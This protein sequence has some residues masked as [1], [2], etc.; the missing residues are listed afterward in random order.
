MARV[1]T[2]ADV[3]LLPKLATTTRMKKNFGTTSRC[4][5]CPSTLALA[6][7]AMVL[8]RARARWRSRRWGTP[9]AHPLDLADVSFREFV[10]WLEDT[11]IRATPLDSRGPLR[12]V[13]AA[14]WPSAFGALA[15]ETGCELD[16][17]S[18]AET[19]RVFDHLLE[20]AVALDYRDNADDLGGVVK[21]LK[22]AAIGA[23]APRAKRQR[24]APASP[25]DRPR[26]EGMD[27][28]EL[29]AKLDQ[30]ARALE[31]DAA[32]VM[33]ANGGDAGGGVE[34]L[35]DACARAVERFVAPFWSRVEAVE[36][37]K[38]K[39]DDGE[40]AARPRPRPRHGT[41]SPRISLRGWNSA[42]RRAPPRRSKPPSPSYASC[43]STTS[44]SSKPPWTRCWCRCKS[45]PATRGPTRNSDAWGADDTPCVVR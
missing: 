6:R 11:K 37:T 39:P 40:D 17:T 14:D 25:E 43:T 12:A 30:L 24:I 31:V 26:M 8:G 15:R 19:T 13:A 41:S 36:R 35:V 10:V 4:S 34:R 32:A 2:G 33:A 45:T 29:R 42:V 7:P 18:P 38:T 3:F 21:D 23:S 27:H 9:R 22:N 1:F 5:V 44:A 20:Q 28:P 16:A